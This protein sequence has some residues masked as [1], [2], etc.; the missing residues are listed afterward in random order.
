[1][2]FTFLA[3]WTYLDFYFAVFGINAKTLAF[4][5]N[6]VITRGFTA[7]FDAGVWLSILYLI[8]L[9]FRSLLKH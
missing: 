6:D 5:L 3:G 1:M 2:V 4:G 9:E 7:V 8:A